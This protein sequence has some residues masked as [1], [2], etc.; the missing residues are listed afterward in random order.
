MDCSMV[1]LSLPTVMRA[2]ITKQKK[3]I[4]AAEVLYLPRRGVFIKKGG[5]YKLGAGC[6][7]IQVISLRALGICIGLMI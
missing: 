1:L 6:R 7:K 5:V 3:G 2:A 4:N